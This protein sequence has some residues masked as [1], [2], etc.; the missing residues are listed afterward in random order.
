M[1][2]SLPAFPGAEGF[3]AAVTGG[4]GGQVIYVTT[5]AASGVGSLQWAI[6]QPGAKTILF[7]VSGLIDARIHLRNGDVTIAGQSSPGGITVR[8]FVTDET[9]YQDQ[10]VRTPDDFAENW[11]LQHIRIRPG[12]NGP[13][14]DG[15]RLR[16]TRNA[17]VDHVSVGNATDEAV[18][19]SY[20][21]N[22]TIQNSIL[23]ET[24]GGHSFYGGMLINYS[25][26]T[27]GFGLDN[28]SIHH[29]LFSRIEGR[30]PEVSRESMAAASSTMNLEIS[31]N[32]YWDPRFFIALGP[33]TGQLTD[34]AGNPYPIYYRL[35]AVN[36]YFR[37]A[38]SF[39]YGMWDDQ[40]LREPSAANNQLFVSGNRMSLYPTR[41]DYELFYCCNDYPTVVVP[42]ATSR[43]A[44]A[45]V[46]RHNFPAIT[47]TQ[48]LDLPS[49]LPNRVGAWPRDPMD[50]RLL[51]LVRENRFDATAPSLNPYGDALLAAY[52]WAPPPAPQ[53]TDSDGMPDTWEVA[54]GLSPT[55]ANNNATTLSNQGY[56]DL[57]V[58]LHELSANRTDPGSTTNP[59]IA[60]AATNTSQLEGHTGSKAFSFTLTRSFST[61]GSHSVAWAVSGSGSNPANAQDFGTGVLPSGNVSFA[62]GEVSK[63]ITVNV[64]GD[65]ANEADETFTVSLSNPTNGASL[66]VAT[67][68]GTILNDDTTP[69][70]NLAIAATNASQ[71]EGQ[72]GGRAFS[73]TLTRSQNT[74]GSHTV[75][76]AVSGSGL[77]PANGADFVGGVLPM[78]RVSF[79]AN[80]VSKL[81]AVNVQGDGRIEENEG[82]TVTLTNPTNGA[83]LTSV[84]A[85]GSIL[86]D[87]AGSSSSWTRLFGTTAFEQAK[88]VAVA[89][90]GSI[91]L[92]GLTEGNLNGQ[93]N[94]G[95]ADGYLVKLF[96]D[97][98]P[99]WSRLVGSGEYDRALAVASSADGAI[100]VAGSSE[101]NL[102][103]QVQQ[104][105]GDG[106]V[107]RFQADG[108]K[109]WT[110]L[111]GTTAAD[112]I[113]AVTTGSDGS[114]YVAGATWGGL[115]GQ[116][117]SG[118]ADGFLTRLSADGIPV[119]TRLLGTEQE[120]RATALARGLDG[121]L[122]VA[123]STNGALHEAVNSGSS[124]AFLSKY[125]PNGL[126]L[127]TRLLGGVSADGA[128]GVVVANDG[129]IYI[130]GSTEGTLQEQASA[131]GGDAFVSK[132]GPDGSHLWSR[133]VGSTD[134][135]AARSITVGRNG[136]VFV[137]GMTAG[138]FDGQP[139]RGQRDGFLSQFSADGTRLTTQWLGTAAADGITAAAAAP[140]G[141]IVLSGDSGGA[142]NGQVNA[143]GTS[144]PFAYKQSLPNL[145]IVVVQATDAA[146]AET[147]DPG[148]FTLS[149]YGSLTEPL[150]VNITL[151]G[152]ATTADIAPIAA[153][154]RFLAGANTAIVNLTVVDDLL[155][156]NQET[157][158]LSIAAG[159][160]YSVGVMARATVTITD[161][162]RNGTADNETLTGDAGRNLL[163]GLA[164]NDNLSGEAGAD[165]LNGGAGFDVLT[166]GADA[167][168]FVVQYGQSI[169]STPDR[170]TDF[171]LGS[172]RI[173]L[174]STTGGVFPMPGRFSRSANSA[175]TT[176]NDLISAVFADC[177]GALAGNQAL[178][179][180]GAALV[181]ATDPAIAG[182]Y[183]VINDASLGF[184]SA[185]DLI[186][187]L[188]VVA[189]A[190]PAV[191]LIPT[192]S[193]FV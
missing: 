56:T 108:S 42:D 58:Y 24:L 27:H 29:N 172:D 75:N 40:I 21:N 62:G 8:G 34:A 123:G 13:S 51:Q 192:S 101:G 64:Q 143:G 115:G 95:F 131:G 181:V 66:G 28:I 46:L 102:D 163:N 185:T 169:S 33:N 39:P 145:P 73:F 26:P 179:A 117:P 180:R 127:W 109:A 151:Q 175:A 135:D 44:Q 10:L 148:Q 74:S 2:A 178:T 122:Y 124:D 140:D 31:S 67:A 7:K 41:S 83:V 88:A 121:S 89:S 45:R 80:E 159:T 81:I 103:G 160:G 120:E 43:L 173:D 61:S 167:D 36:N 87:D 25:N 105:S 3:G 79:A 139:N 94:N 114:V 92:A 174:L 99:S 9:P 110:T 84:S 48:A 104:G 96:A 113:V 166:G 22:I 90:D 182:T 30:L 85:T 193:W 54:K 186:L 164:G 130:C 155:V 53:D 191:G 189:G 15:L 71:L 112:E 5:T 14:D 153:T 144:D 37:T 78:G 35:N 69:A 156:E 76:W 57:E 49:V 72:S 68:T 165:Q 142:L 17:I 32:L 70:A 19:I 77:N 116:I 125:D 11:I 138:S 59:S 65:L 158:I 63:L 20:S 100:Y 16:Y 177:N 161:N 184:Q 187:N 136:N 50:A 23:A 6:D 106:F 170:I 134:F 98:T 91:Y 150:S 86:N 141:S 4:R 137:A 12:L 147:S 176:I 97:G 132:F 18:E 146:A 47:Y 111:L 119:W 190:L 133:L 162:D 157:V 55:V 188:T 168:I 93:L 38:T 128:T 52:G 149:R 1:S 154:A 107:S 126:R 152:T 60:I 129:A 118:L 171:G 82:F 183:L